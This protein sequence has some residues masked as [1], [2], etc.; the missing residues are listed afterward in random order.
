MQ[1]ALSAAVPLAFVLQGGFEALHV[2]QVA[3]EIESFDQKK[4]F[5]I[6]HVYA[7]RR[8]A[9][10]GETIELTIGL[11]GENGALVTR[12]VSYAAPI[13]LGAGPLYFTVS[14]AST[15][16]ITEFRQAVS[17]APRSPAQLI[18]TVN[19]LKVN[20]KAYV[21]VW[22]SDAAYQLQGE[23]YPAPPPSLAMILA[24]AQTGYGGL[25]QAYNSKLAEMEIDGGGM[26]V[27]GSKT[28]QVDIKE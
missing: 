18:D 3:L 4:Q 5:Q 8:D 10:P 17:A 22:R 13:G 26:V 16:N 28:I 11:A 2:K 19:Q 27:T 7:G 1:V 6:D 21:R 12:K 9:R 25:T 23:D 14:D 24:R 15:A 20:T